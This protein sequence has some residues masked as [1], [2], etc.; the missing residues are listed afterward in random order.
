MHGTRVVGG[1]AS[2]CLRKKPGG[3][4]MHGPCAKM[5]CFS[6]EVERCFTQPL[7]QAEGS[8]DPEGPTKA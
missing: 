6:L 8:H 1:R 7:L 5:T 2:E 4:L 3:V